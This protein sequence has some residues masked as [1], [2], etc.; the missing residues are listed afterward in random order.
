MN[1]FETENVK[2]NLNLDVRWMK[3]S[4]LCVYYFYLSQFLWPFNLNGF[5]SFN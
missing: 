4:L 2:L 1:K 5:Y 3:I